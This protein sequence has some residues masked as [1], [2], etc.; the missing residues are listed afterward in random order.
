MTESDKMEFG[1][2]LG[3]LGFALGQTVEKPMLDAYWHF[4]RDLDLEG[5][6]RAALAAG[7]TLRFFPKPSELRD[8]A[9]A[10][11]KAN[12]LIAWDA[13]RAAMR[14]YGYTNGVDFGPLVNAVVRNMGG[15]RRLDE[16]ATA[17]LD[18]WGKKEFERVYALLALQ[19]QHA[20]N[21]AP[22]MGAFEGEPVRIQIAGHVVSSHLV[23]GAGVPSIVRQL[24]QVKSS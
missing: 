7:R 2:A 3:A 15:W 20:L 14:R 19:D 17:E 22:L 5:F 8:L 1:V 4:L 21:G 12:A 23:E 11:T 13:V 10:G 24:A 16:M 9:G 6:K 18:V